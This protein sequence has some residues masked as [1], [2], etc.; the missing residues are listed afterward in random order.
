MGDGGGRRAGLRAGAFVALLLVAAVALPV[1][2]YVVEAFSSRAENWILVVYLV[3]V[4]AVGA[5][6]GAAVPAV[7][8]ATAT[9]GRRAIVWAGFALVAAVV[10]YG[11]WLVVIAG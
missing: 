9:P 7:G 4:A 10:S 1:S 8:P 11:I 2:A 5:S 6:I 3:I